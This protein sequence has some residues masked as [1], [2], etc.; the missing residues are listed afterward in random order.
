MNESHM[1]CVT[2]SLVTQ[3][4]MS[5]AYMDIYTRTIHVL[6]VWFQ[7]ECVTQIHPEPPGVFSSAW[8]SSKASDG[9][10]VH[11]EGGTLALDWDLGSAF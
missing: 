3:M 8:D 2:H 11:K 9:D 5:D 7:F 6:W 4:Y 1:F 10:G